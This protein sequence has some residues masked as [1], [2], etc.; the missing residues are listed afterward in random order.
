MFPIAEIAQNG[1]SYSDFPEVPLNAEKFE[2]ILSLARDQIS[3]QMGQGSLF[4]SH[5]HA[6]IL[7]EKKPK[8]GSQKK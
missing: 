5:D 8:F 2:T 3:R 4:S 1:L 6:E 7:L